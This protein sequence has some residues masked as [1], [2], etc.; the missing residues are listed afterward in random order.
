MVDAPT[1]KVLVVAN[2][3]AESPEL[4]H[5]MRQRAAEGAV[6]F[7][8]VVPVTAHGMTWAT[9]MNAGGAEAEQ[10]LTAALGGMRRAGL[11]VDGRLG[12]PDPIAAVQD[13]VNFDTFD[14][15]IVSTLPHGISRWL[16]LD[17]P[18]RVERS[19]GL[20]VRHVTASSR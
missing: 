14:E 10:H 9:D 2:R 15:V 12:D 8:L 18:R 7:T 6:G 17:L 16:G 19:T 3:T 11:S 1:R 4:L 13:A 5:V 20:P